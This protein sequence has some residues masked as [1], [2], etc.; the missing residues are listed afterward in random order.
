MFYGL[1]SM[2]WYTVLTVELDKELSRCVT[3]EMEAI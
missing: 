3:G 2:E 1:L